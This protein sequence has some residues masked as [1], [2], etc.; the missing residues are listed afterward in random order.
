MNLDDLLLKMKR[1]NN[2]EIGQIA[3]KIVTSLY[4]ELENSGAIEEAKA[5]LPAEK[6]MLDTAKQYLGMIEGSP[7]HL[8]MVQDYNAI[9]PLPVGYYLKDTDAWCAAFLSVVATMAGY[10][11]VPLECSVERLKNLFMKKNQYIPI[12]EKIRDRQDFLPQAGDYIFL[13]RTGNKWLD[14][15]GLVTLYIPASGTIYYINGNCNNKVCISRIAIE[16]RFLA[17]FAR[18]DYTGGEI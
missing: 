11:N 12:T 5:I 3:N 2:T 16:S 10:K 18:P 13:D 1:A 6:K 15:V 7:M 9:D 17:G 14:H 8:K 4:E